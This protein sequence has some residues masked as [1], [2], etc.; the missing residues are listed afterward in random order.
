MRRSME[1]PCWFR[2][3]C[4]RWPVGLLAIG[5]FAQLHFSVSAAC[6]ADQTA[7]PTV[8]AGQWLA[9]GDRFG[10][11]YNHSRPAAAGPSQTQEESPWSVDSEHIFGF[12]E[13]TDIGDRGDVEAEVDSIGRFGKRSGSYAA[14]TTAFELKYTATDNFRIAPSLDVSTHNIS[15]VPGLED[16]KQLALQGAGVDLRYQVLNRTKAPFGLTF[17]V[18]PHL[19]RIDEGS[20]ERVSQFS[21]ETAALL[22]K[23]LVPDRLFGALNFIYEPEWTRSRETGMTER[24]S[25]VGL[26]A[27]LTAQL[28]A[29]FLVGGEIRY[30]RKYEGVGLNTFAGDAVFVGPN[31]YVKLAKNA[32]M[33]VAWN[34]QVAGGAADEPGRLDLTNFER[35]EVRFRV[36]VDF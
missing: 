21:V 35:H 34:V 10:K 3:S 19:G 32:N 29:G 33:S 28:F 26:G 17:V 6:A 1:T 22:D 14:T 15:N 23:D 31:V 13:G 20:G 25:T 4:R 18:A 30:M 7:G 16:R 24:T 27:A 9:Q 5:A 8:T 11:V 12:T 2:Q 36:G